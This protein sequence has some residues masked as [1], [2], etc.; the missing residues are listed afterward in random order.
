MGQ[1]FE[2][3]VNFFQ[4]DGWNFYQL[5]DQSIISLNISADNGTWQC[6]AQANDEKENFAFYS[7]CPVN[8]PE[9]KRI[10]IA[11]YI[12]RA[13]H[14]LHSGNFEMDFEDGE[15]RYK[16]SAKFTGYNHKSAMFEHLVYANINIMDLYLPGIMRVIYSNG[17]PLE[18]IQEI[19]RSLE[20]ESESKA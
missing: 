13:N 20:E 10:A 14:G 3:M 11:E 16:T 9:P 17:S 4:E 2:E 15:I 12:T 19:E 18:A 8:V 6:L 5:G 7:I 1:V